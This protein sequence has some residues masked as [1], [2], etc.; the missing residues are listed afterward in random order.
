VTGGRSLSISFEVVNTGKRAGADVP[1]MYVAREGSRNP[2]RLAGFTRVT[3]K[4][5]ESRRV[6]LVAEP[7]IVA[8]YD[9]AL[10]GWRIVGGKYRV[11]LARDAEDRTLVSTATI[12]AAT[13]KP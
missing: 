11:A 7:R 12:E 4:P 6:T 9:T 1:Q 5:G 10:P 3:L 2:M 8:D 13:M